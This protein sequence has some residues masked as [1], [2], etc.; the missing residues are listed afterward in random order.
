MRYIHVLAE[1][2]TEVEFVKQVLCG[3][4]IK[5]DLLLNSQAVETSRSS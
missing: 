4:F 2:Q 3:Y 5:Y 1:G